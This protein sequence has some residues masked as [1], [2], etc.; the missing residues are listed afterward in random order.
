MYHVIFKF[1][2]VRKKRHLLKNAKCF[3]FFNKTNIV[4]TNTINKKNNNLHWEKNN[5]LHSKNNSLHSKNNSLHL[6]NNSLHS[7]NNNLRVEARKKEEDDKL[8]LHKSSYII[9]SCKINEIINIL[10][11]C[12]KLKNS[13]NEL[14]KNISLNLLMNKENL[15]YTD[16]TVL[17]KKFS[18]IKCK[19]YFLFCYFKDVLL[20]NIH[21]LSYDELIDVYF[22]FT[23]LN[24]FHYN[25]FFLIEK[26]IFHNFHKLDLK[27]LIYLVQCFNKKKIITKN[28]LTILLY[29]ISKNINDLNT[30]QLSVVF[31][32]FKNFNINNSILINSLIHNFKQNI[33]SNEDVKNI[34]LFY[35]F[36]SYVYTKCKKNHTYYEKQKELIKLLK[37]FRLFDEEQYKEMIHEKGSHSTEEENSNVFFFNVSDA[38]RE[39]I[40]K[41]KTSLIVKTEMDSIDRDSG[42]DNN[43]DIKSKLIRF[44]NSCLYKNVELE[45]L[46]EQSNV[47]KK[48]GFNLNLIYS[49]N[50]ICKNMEMITKK[51]LKHMSIEYLCLLSHCISN[52]NKNKFLLEK[53]AE[54]V[55]KQS[56]KL[57]P[58]LISF[59][60]LSFSK[61][62]HKHGSLIYYSLQFFY[63]YSNFFSINDVGLLCKGLYNFAIKEHELIN[64]LNEYIL[65]NIDTFYA[66]NVYEQGGKVRDSCSGSGSSSDEKCENYSNTKCLNF[67]D[68]SSNKEQI[69]N[70]YDKI[71]KKIDKNME[72]LN[73]EDTFVNANRIYIDKEN[74]YN[75]KNNRDS[76]NNV[77]SYYNNYMNFS[78]IDYESIK[79][80]MYSTNNL[81]NI[82]I[83][84][85]IYIN[86]II[87]IL[88]YYAFNMVNVN[89]ILD[90]FC[91]IFLKSSLNYILYSRIFHSFY[92]LQYKKKQVYELIRKFNK[93]QPLNQVMYKEKHVIN[94]LQSL[95]YFYESDKEKLDQM[96]SSI[97]ATVSGEASSNVSSSNNYGDNN[98][99]I[100]FY[101]LP[102]NYLSFLFNF[103]QYYLTFLFIKNNNYVLSDFLT[104]IRDISLDQTEYVYLHKPQNLLY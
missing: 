58:S 51:Q 46:K 45:K 77:T 72:R 24:Y 9:N 7:K 66:C 10:N 86:N 60:L 8:I 94:L 59:L 39:K 70:A 76:K 90:C 101:V 52:I 103:P 15:R 91:T 38:N 104:N 69:A 87:Y 47:L 95:L 65:G 54:E 3:I 28:C 19:N 79:N 21:L 99:D 88:E 80:N 82:K 74:E 61:S 6:E 49:I 68:S 73:Y 40:L 67:F 5:S 34:P 85:S 30:F 36:L 97:S 93:Y 37:Q 62:N 71:E 31:R 27:K 56:T 26:K 83:N 43:N 22:S 75:K 96:D 32:F 33:S 50:S 100:Y 20:D 35:N 102:K 48:D 1:N 44:E 81:Y 57:T 25:F 78:Y 55:G 16:I 23:N 89:T 17:V 92:L 63:K 41:E 4:T 64:V 84:K 18:I 29:S 53:I 14:L 98:F 12:I 11:L 13:D 2:F 42:N